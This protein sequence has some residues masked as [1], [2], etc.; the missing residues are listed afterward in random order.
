MSAPQK[1]ILV[2][3]RPSLYR[4][5]FSPETD[6]RLK[7]LGRV[8]FNEQERDWTSEQLAEEIGN[9]DVVITSWRSPRFTDEVLA[10]ATR[11]KLVAHSAGSIR[12]MFSQESLERG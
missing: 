6:A 10:N 9:Y 3:P 1:N 12:F 2:L 4:Q 11:L 7:Q 8:T 5:L